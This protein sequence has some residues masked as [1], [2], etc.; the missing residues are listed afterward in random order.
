MWEALAAFEGY[1]FQTA[2][3][4]R[5][6]YSIKGNEIFFSRKKKSVTRATVNIALKNVMQIR[7]EGCEVSGPKKLHCFGA[8]YLHPVFIRIG[9]IQGGEYQR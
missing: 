8:S 2:K 5:F 6:Y 1:P 4:I 7:E 9:V 3:G